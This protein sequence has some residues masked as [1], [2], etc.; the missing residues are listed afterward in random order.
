LEEYLERDT[1]REAVATAEAAAEPQDWFRLSPQQRRV[2]ALLRDGDGAGGGAV[3]AVGCAFAVSGELTAEALAGALAAAV[4]RHEILRT[5]FLEL[6]GL[7]VPVQTVLAEGRFS[8]ESVPA[9]VWAAAD[10]ASGLPE[11]VATRLRELMDRLAP[12]AAGAPL[13]ASCLRQGPD[14]SFVLL[15]LPAL[16]ADAATLELLAAELAALI[17]ARGRDA[18]PPSAGLPPQ[19]T[20]QYADAAEIFNRLPPDDAPATVAAVD[21]ALLAV[22]PADEGDLAAGAGAAADERPAGSRSGDRRRSG[23]DQPALRTAAAGAAAGL[24]AAPALAVDGQ[25]AGA[26]RRCLRRPRVRGDGGG[27]GTLHRLSAVGPG[28]GRRAGVERSGRQRP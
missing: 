25:A 15:A 2:W 7:A 4:A 24:L 11:Q 3:A 12:L 13:A 22:R 19:P 1:D 5:G 10:Q 6:P 26:L 27:A 21:R 17:A 20:F 14:R 18:G 8:L 16:C 28:G 23:G 9:A